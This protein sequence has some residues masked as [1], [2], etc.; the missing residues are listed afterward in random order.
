M[1]LEKE[2]DVK[3]KN[4]D[5]MRTQQWKDGSPQ[6]LRRGTLGP[7]NRKEKQGQ[8]ALRLVLRAGYFCPGGY[9]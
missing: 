1:M 4:P 3:Q 5:R 9:V 6:P 8:F 7:C 2:N